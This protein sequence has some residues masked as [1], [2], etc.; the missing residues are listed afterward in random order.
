MTAGANAR[1]SM[2]DASATSVPHPNIREVEHLG[3]PWREAAWRGGH[4]A[5]P[6]GRGAQPFGVRV[7]S[8]VMS[9]MTLFGTSFRVCFTFTA[10]RTVR[11]AVLP[12]FDS[13]FGP[14]SM[15]S[16]TATMSQ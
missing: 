1:S 2:P 4:E 6:W 9:P 16:T 11:P 14:K 7:T 10:V 8:R 12:I 15:S 3:R 5:R 13:V